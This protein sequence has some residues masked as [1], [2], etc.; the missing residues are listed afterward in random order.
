MKFGKSFRTLLKIDRTH[1][2]TRMQSQR[3]PKLVVFDLDQCLWSPEMY[4]LDDIP[5]K[6]DAVMGDLGG[7]LMGVIG[8]RS[9]YEIIKLFPAALKWLQ[10]YYQNEF[11]G[12][13]IAAASSADTPQAVRIGRAAMSIIEIFPGVTM[14]DVF[15][16]GWEPSF[17][18]NLQIGRTAPLSAD[19]A[20]SHFP[21]L[22]E[23]TGIPYNE[24]VFF[25][26]CLWGDHCRNVE[27]LCEGVVTR[28]TPRGLQ[29]DD[30]QI[31]LNDFR[32][33][34]LHSDSDAPEDL[35][36]ITDSYLDS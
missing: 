33:R 32:T 20:R 14:R 36:S 8:V 3:F 9:G 24:M 12:V 25:D 27:T 19:K 21:I 2:L 30:W 10:R 7:S 4:T 18:G 28:R 6:A 35:G 16:K 11:P 13:R 26:D 31:V 5:T 29:E 1:F 17:E 22:R 23:L 34:Y 15:G